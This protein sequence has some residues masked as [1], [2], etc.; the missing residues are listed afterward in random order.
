MCK[1]LNDVLDSFSIWIHIGAAATITVVCL[2]CYLCVSSV[3][4]VWFEAEKCF[5]CVPPWCCPRL[6]FFSYRTSRNCLSCSSVV[7]CVGKCE[8]LASHT[9]ASSQ[10]QTQKW[11]R[12]C[13]SWHFGQ[14]TVMCNDSDWADPNEERMVQKHQ[15]HKSES[16]I[17]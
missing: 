10:P 14:E 11:H 13:V 2:N 12:W 5:V 7:I 1:T 16:L 9:S 17:H 8:M 6:P 3:L 4:Q 15:V